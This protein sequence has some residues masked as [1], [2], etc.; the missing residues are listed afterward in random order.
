MYMRGFDVRYAQ[1]GPKDDVPDSFA[2][3]A[4]KV[5][6]A[7]KWPLS[8]PTFCTS[9]ERFISLKSRKSGNFRAGTVI[10]NRASCV[11]VTRTD[12]H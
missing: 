6:I 1:F 9:A 5:S 8:L 12:G 10:A 7:G 2:T 11:S 3:G 4:R